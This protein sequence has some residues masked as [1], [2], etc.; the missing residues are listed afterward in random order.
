MVRGG[1]G[2]LCSFRCHQRVTRGHQSASGPSD[3]RA[4]SQCIWRGKG[5]M[6]MISM[7]FRQQRV[8][9][10]HS[11]RSRTLFWQDKGKQQT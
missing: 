5:D 9:L 6:E 1:G 11:L 7:G 8:K 2:G 3:T 4:K 10:H